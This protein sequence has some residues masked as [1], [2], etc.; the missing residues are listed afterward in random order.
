MIA[1]LVAVVVADGADVAAVAR[2]GLGPG[3]FFAFCADFLALAVIFLVPFAGTLPID[4]LR[5]VFLFFLMKAG[6]SFRIEP[7]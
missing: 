2:T 5:C 4:F 6:C 1:I 7:P 3:A